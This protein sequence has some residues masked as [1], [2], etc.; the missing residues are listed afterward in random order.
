VGIPAG[1]PKYKDASKCYLGA[2]LVEAKFYNTV[3]NE[4]MTVS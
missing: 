2:F 4:C 3:I 1:S